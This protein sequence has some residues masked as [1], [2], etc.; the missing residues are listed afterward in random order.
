MSISPIKGESLEEY[1]GDLY[2]AKVEVNEIKEL[3]K[4]EKTKEL[5]KRSHASLKHMLNVP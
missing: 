2:K 1:F 4:V 5:G 3:G